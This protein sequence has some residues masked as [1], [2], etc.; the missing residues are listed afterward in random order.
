MRGD[1]IAAAARVGLGFARLP[2]LL[3]QQDIAAGRLVRVLHDFEADELGIFV[4]YPH[5]E[6]MPA[7]LRV[8]IDHMAGWFEAERKAGRTC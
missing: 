4:V 2:L 3:V 8:F 1:A 6:R 5:R 7:K